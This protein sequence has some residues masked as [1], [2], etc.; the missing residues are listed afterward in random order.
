MT[1]PKLTPERKKKIKS[2]LSMMNKQNLRF[3]PIAPPLVEMMHLV[4]SDAEINYLLKMG[5]DLYDYS[6]AEQAS[7]MPQDQFQSF[8]NKMQRKGLVHI[9]Y[10]SDGKEKYRLNAIAVGWYECMMHYIMGKPN[11]KEFSEKWLS[12]GT[13]NR[14]L[15]RLNVKGDTTG[16][17]KSEGILSMEP[18]F[19]EQQFLFPTGDQKSVEMTSTIQG[20]L[21]TWIFNP[22]K[23]K[24]QCLAPN[25]DISMSMYIIDRNYFTTD[26]E[27]W[28]W[29]FG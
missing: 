1:P 19:A 2:L 10:D 26:T 25:S 9:E 3:I 21:V 5:T 28:D 7:S 23:N 12:N 15:N 4:T 22:E 16:K 20:E 14:P 13:I 8:F 6:Q 27:K 24:V 17:G 29:E 18:R 11:E